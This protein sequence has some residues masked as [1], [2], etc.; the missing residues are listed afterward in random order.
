MTLRVAVEI[1]EDVD[2]GVIDRLRRPT[3]GHGGDVDETVGIGFD[4]LAIGAA[5]VLA[6]RDGVDLEAAA[7][8]QAEQ[9]LD[10]VRRGGIV[11][12]GG[13]VGDSNAVTARARE[14]KVNLF[15]GVDTETLGLARPS[16]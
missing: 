11:V 10:Q 12:V 16:P 8:M 7:I 9:A 15:P 6:V 13:Y 4:S 3:V 5:V 2:T 1:D 14:D